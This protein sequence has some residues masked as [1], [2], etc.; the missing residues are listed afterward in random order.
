[1]LH[2]ASISIEVLPPSSSARHAIWHCTVQNDPS[3]AMRCQSAWSWIQDG[4]L[5]QYT[6]S[7]D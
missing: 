2:P 1:M 7:Y 5:L 4:R 3:A 6:F